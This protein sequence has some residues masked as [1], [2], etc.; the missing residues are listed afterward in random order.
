MDSKV[1]AFSRAVGW[2]IVG[3]AG[4][5]LFILVDLIQAS[6]L[7]NLA[8]GVIA[9]PLVWIAWLALIF[10]AEKFDLMGDRK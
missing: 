1:D 4:F 7:P 6:E 2:L 8:K 3:I 5:G 9:V 10:M